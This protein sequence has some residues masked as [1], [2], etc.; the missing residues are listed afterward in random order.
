M[1]LSLPFKTK[2][3]KQLLSISAIILAT[4]N[5]QAQEITSSKDSAGHRI[6]IGLNSSPKVLVRKP[7]FGNSLDAAIFST[8][9]I[10]NGGKQSL[11]TLRFSAFFHL[12]FTYNYNFSNN[13]GIYTGLDLKNIGF[14]EKYSF[15]DMTAKQR[16]Y[17]LG[18]PVG[19]RL[20]NMKSR[21]YF[22][23][24]GGLD[25][26]V[27]YK[28]KFWS[29]TQSKVKTNDW[30][31]N[32]TELLLPYVFA[33]VAVSG[34]TFKIQYYPTNFLSNT[35]L[36]N[37]RNTKVNLLLFSV[38]RDMDFGNRNKVKKTK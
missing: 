2:K 37:P 9:L 20:G 13:V 18:V 34:T 1:Q 16:V 24:G 15:N 10:D 14:I 22:F 25:V 19:L 17:A 26:A 23:A 11:G 31:S 27:H 35:A 7:Y 33:G 38:G 28:Y 32:N 21:D 12:G 3:M 6:K 36:Y 4:T 5:L 30:F 8:A 29:N